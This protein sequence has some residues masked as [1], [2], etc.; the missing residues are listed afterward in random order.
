MFSLNESWTGTR[1]KKEEEKKEK[2]RKMMFY[3]LLEINLE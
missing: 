1:I 3:L 2:V